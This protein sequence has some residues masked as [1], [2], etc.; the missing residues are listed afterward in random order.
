VHDVEQTE[1]T[2]REVEAIF[3]IASPDEFHQ[4]LSIA[5]SADPAPANRNRVR[6]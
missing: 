3:A 4:G 2:V 5:A 1:Q 6:S